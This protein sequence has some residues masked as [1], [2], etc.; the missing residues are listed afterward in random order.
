MNP[1]SRWQYGMGIGN[2]SGEEADR[3]MNDDELWLCLHGTRRTK[4]PKENG[5]G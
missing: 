1:R 2:R 4:Y 5:N 3:F